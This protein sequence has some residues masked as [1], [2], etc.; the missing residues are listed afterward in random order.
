MSRSKIAVT[1]ARRTRSIA[2]R[3]V[4]VIGRAAA[5]AWVWDRRPTKWES[6]ARS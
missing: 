4:S 3:S 6:V 1:A 2:S 5:S